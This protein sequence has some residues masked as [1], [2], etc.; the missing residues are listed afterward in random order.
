MTVKPWPKPRLT[1]PLPV[2]PEVPIRML[3]P[4]VLVDT[5]WFKLTAAP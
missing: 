4:A 5:A 3:P 1:P 2:R